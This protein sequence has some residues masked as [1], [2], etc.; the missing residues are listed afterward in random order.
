[1]GLKEKTKVVMGKL[2]EQTAIALDISR[3]K[4]EGW[5]MT[6]TRL[7]GLA[8]LIGIIVSISLKQ[9]LVTLIISCTLHL[10][11]VFRYSFR[12]SKGIDLWNNK[13]KN[14]GQQMTSE[15]GLNEPRN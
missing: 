14:D 3:D 1:M 10:Q 2:D 11:I 12:T 8:L 6:Y 13:P 7:I 5:L 4:V 15:N 9:Y